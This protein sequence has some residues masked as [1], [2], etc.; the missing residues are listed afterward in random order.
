MVTPNIKNDNIYPM[1]LDSHP[2]GIISDIRSL[3]N[4]ATTTA[5]AEYVPNLTINSTKSSSFI[6]NGVFSSL[7]SSMIC[8]FNL[9]AVLYLPTTS[10]STLPLPLIMLVPLMRM[11]EGRY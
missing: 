10:T 5:M 11:G 4:K 6:Y 1:Y 8:S 9:P 2:L 7:S 3:M